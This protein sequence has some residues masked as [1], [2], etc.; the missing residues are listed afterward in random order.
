MSVTNPVTFLTQY[1]PDL[2]V[3]AGMIFASGY[4]RDFGSQSDNP[5]QSNSWESQYQTLFKSA[6]LLELRKKFAGPGWT[7][8]SSLPIAP[9]R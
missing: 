2:L 3:A 8:L 6:N 1:L 7:S 5:Q 4:M 9:V